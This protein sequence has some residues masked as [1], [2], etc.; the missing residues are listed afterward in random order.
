MLLSLPSE[1]VEHVEVFRVHADAWAGRERVEGLDLR[2]LEKRL[3]ILSFELSDSYG[4]LAVSFQN[5]IALRDSE[6]RR[7]PPSRPTCYSNST[8]S[9]IPRVFPS[10]PLPSLDQPRPAILVHH[11]VARTKDSDLPPVPSSCTDLL[12][13]PYGPLYHDDRLRVL[14]ALEQ[15]LS[16]ANS[17]QITLERLYLSRLM[18]PRI[19]KSTQQVFD[20]ILEV[21]RSRGIEV[22][23]V[24]PDWSL[25]ASW[26]PRFFLEHA[27]DVKTL[28]A[29]RDE[30]H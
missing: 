19:Y 24:E 6:T 21:C 27:K 26:I 29:N 15:A 5:F 4:H 20:R 22:N 11:C 16:S 23:L 18:A 25:G 17:P 1:L 9:S 30:Q 14:N 28:K 2:V 8:S 12:L 13:A 7:C 10:L 3:R